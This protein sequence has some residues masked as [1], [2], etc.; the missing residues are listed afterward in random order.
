MMGAM[1]WAGHSTNVGREQPADRPRN[2]L[3]AH[4]T[5]F[6]IVNAFL[7]IQDI[8][9]GGGLEYAYWTTIPWGIGLIAH[10]YAY[11]KGR[12]ASGQTPGA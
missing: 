5:A 12:D 3:I 8:A 2:E 6:T 7:W 1:I 10:A 4:A 9:Q 11:M